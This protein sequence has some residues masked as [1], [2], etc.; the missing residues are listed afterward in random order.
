MQMES[1]LSAIW[2]PQQTES[3]CLQICQKEGEGWEPLQQAGM[4]VLSVG[5]WVGQQHGLVCKANAQQLGGKGRN[6]WAGTVAELCSGRVAV[7]CSTGRQ[8]QCPGV[9]L[10]FSMALH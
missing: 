10:V 3:W 6:E 7:G 1:I 8:G 2:L 9:L 5:L 4:G